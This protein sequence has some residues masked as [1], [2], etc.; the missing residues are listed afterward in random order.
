[1]DLFADA[2]ALFGCLAVG[3][4]ERLAF[5]SRYRARRWCP[6]ALRSLAASLFVR[7][8]EF[9]ALKQLNLINN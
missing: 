7:R 3:L 1:M 4:R 2:G 9:L 6:E 8:T 5:R